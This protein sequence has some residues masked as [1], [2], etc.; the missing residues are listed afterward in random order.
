MKSSI[1]FGMALAA[2]LTAATQVPSAANPAT[3]AL[4]KK[5][6]KPRQ[7]IFTTAAQYPRKLY[8]VRE[9]GAGLRKLTRSPVADEE[10]ATWSPDGARIAFGRA[11][12]NKPRHL[13]LMKAN[14]SGVKRL[15]SDP[16]AS[17]SAPAW[18]P[19]GRK[20][21]FVRSYSDTHANLFLVDVKTRKLQRLTN[22][23]GFDGDPA[24]SPNGRNILFASKRTG[25]YRLYVA[26]SD[27][28]N[29]REIAAKQTGYGLVFP[30]WSPDGT[31][32]AFTEKIGEAV[33]IFVSGLNGEGRKQLTKLGGIN[34]LPAWS[35]NGATLAFQHYDSTTARGSLR[36]MDA[37]GGNQRTFI[38]DLGGYWCG[39][40]AWRP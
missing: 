5:K 11:M 40:P 37:S 30:A 25:E 21:L 4:D 23:D 19:N 29:V 14:G 31:K 24:W 38:A 15:T 9:N 16:V 13:Y 20:I 1:R 10:G 36:L 6:P 33:E 7:L 34:F 8:L 2:L 22:T 39:R 18:S 17:D 32:I 12:P 26:D 27:G 3:F 35:R 28:G